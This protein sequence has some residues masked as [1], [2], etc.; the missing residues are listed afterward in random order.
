M[1]IEAERLLAIFE[2][3][4]A[5]LDKAL[6]KSRGEAQRSFKAIETAGTRAESTLARVG[7][8][9]LPGMERVNA[10][11]REMRRESDL[12]TS[13]LGG[14]ARGFAGALGAGLSIQAA[15][16]LLDTSARIR[17]SLKV[18]GLE[19]DNLKQVYD[20]LFQSAQR[21][22]APIESLTTLYGRLAQAQKTIGASQQDLLNFTDK[23]SLA[24]RVSGTNAQSASGALLQLSQALGGGVVRAEEFNSVLEGAPAII[25]TVAAGLREAGG[26]ISTLRQLVLDG[27]VSSEAFFRAFLA[28]AGQLE[29]RVKTS[30]TT[31]S[32]AFIR[33]QNVLVDLAGRFDTATG[34][35]SKLAEFL[36]T[37]LVNAI[38]EVGTI[39]TNTA[40]GPLAAFV[41]A[42]NKVTDAIVGLGA[43]IGEVSGLD[44]IGRSLGAEPYRSTTLGRSP[45]QIRNRIGELQRQLAD[46]PN[47]AKPFTDEIQKQIDKLRE[48]LRLIEQI[49]ENQR[50][51]Q[52][53]TYST[54]G[55][56][57]ATPD[58]AASGG[59]KPI[60]LADYPIGGGGSATSSGQ[61]P[62]ESAAT[63]LAEQA[64]DRLTAAIAAQSAT[65]VDAAALL[66][67]KS[68][69]AN[70]GDINAFLK[71]G[72]IDLNAATTAWC[73]AFVNSAL[74]QVGISGSGSDVATDFLN[75]G[76][77]IDPSQIQ[78]GDVLVQDRGLGAGQVGGHVGL[79]TGLVRFQEGILQLQMLSG[80]AS[81]KVQE[82]WVNASEVVARRATDAFQVP[83]EAL[84]HIGQQ[85][86]AAKAETEAATAAVQQQGQAY[87]RLGQVAQ[88]ALNGLATALADG[89]IEGE[90]LLQIVMQIV[91]Q[92]IS[93]PGFSFPGGAGGGLLSLIRSVFGFAKGGI[94]AHGRPLPLPRFAR[95]GVSRS[96]AIFGEAGPEAAVPLPDGRRIPVELSMP[97]ARHGRSGGSNDTV[98]VMLRDDSGR[99]A[100]IADQRIVSRSGTI[101]NVAVQRANA[102]APAAIAKYRNE[103]GNSDYRL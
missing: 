3:R 84:R 54:V 80:N 62:A 70:A 27:K 45:E 21:N 39:A 15:Q 55:G 35:S 58:A 42:V 41:G 61:T 77:K 43:E 57:A 51:L 47:A 33:L 94:A 68:E 99:M 81:N 73:A 65:A 23:V 50:L 38:N 69:T 28:G 49:G 56:E 40:T 19:G 2:A 97:V 98:T 101:V 64:A 26:S 32:Q 34:A 16:Q 4:F 93:M 95:G 22:A 76:V 5:S 31:I 82:D 92:M 85:S 67:G 102:S 53:S 59:V 46:M 17:N 36:S 20:Q 100:E 30:E 37:T 60:T 91:Q 72:G 12:T 8:R 87:E 83:T 103:R 11:L 74:A 44:Q 7:S 18:T 6:A 1:A 10:K 86:S 29:E 75:W 48:E 24:L 96:A 14:F 9:G 52:R 66:L 88:T 79:A 89:K 71:R 63:R 90:E 25:Q 78:R 13:S